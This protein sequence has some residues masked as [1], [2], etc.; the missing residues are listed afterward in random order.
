[1]KRIVGD[2]PLWALRKAGL[3]ELVEL[4]VAGIAS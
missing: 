3:V 1:L 2:V 4:E